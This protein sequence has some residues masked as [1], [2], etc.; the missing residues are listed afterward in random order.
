MAG[1][2][3]PYM[4]FI[5]AII[6]LLMKTVQL[7]M[8][9]I[10]QPVVLGEVLLGFLL[11]PSGLYLIYT[12]K[13][14][15]SSRIGE[16]LNIETGEIGNAVKAIQFTAEF[17]AL[18]LLFKVGLEINFTSLKRVGKSSLFS[19]IGGITFPIIGGIGFVLVA[20]NFVPDLL[21]TN[22]GGLIQVA[23]FIGAALTATSI[24]ISTRIFL[25]LDKIKTKAAQI[26]VGA[27]VIDDIISL[28]ILSLAISYV[29]DSANFNLGSVGLIVLNVLIFFAIALFLYRFIMPWM[30][31]Q[32]KKS[33][34]R[35]MPLF[36]AIILMLMLSFIAYLLGLATIIGAFTAGVII[37]NEEKE[38]LH[39]VEHDF[40]ILEKLFVPIFFVSIGLSINLQTVLNGTIIILGLSLAIIAI[41]AKIIGG[42]LGSFLAKEN[43]QTSRI[44]GISMAAKGEVTLIFAFTAYDLGVFSAAVYAA[45]VLLVVVDSLVIPSL[46]KIFLTRSELEL[47]C[48]DEL[49]AKDAIKDQL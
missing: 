23:L 19:A 29:K 27:A 17:A 6:F 15:P 25:D 31:E 16:W 43:L 35:F 9:K 32:V 49:I 36:S 13:S 44:I 20:Y 45:V 34:D 11:G 24:G 48:D 28:T 5:L 12:S 37:E 14:N 33:D 3:Y 2:E 1:S 38:Y 42:S 30:I 7:L 41:L 8:V 21:I 18:L 4:F 47:C 22:N 40:E 39:M 26:L 10:K 46:I